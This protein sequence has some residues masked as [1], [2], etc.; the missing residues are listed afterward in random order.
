MLVRTP[1]PFP[2]ESLFGYVL[3]VSE[4]NGYDTPG[5]ILRLAGFEEGAMKD[6]R[7]P[8]EQLAVILGVPPGSLEHIAYQRGGEGS[9]L[10]ILGHELGRTLSGSPLRISKPALC[11]Y[12]VEES[13]HIAAFWDLRSAVACPTHGCRV[14][15]TCP[16]CG[17]ALT[18]FR[19]GLLTCKCGA[20]LSNGGL[21]AT[22]QPLTELMGVIKAMLDGQPL[23]SL[24]N[25]A[26]FPLEHLE[27]ISLR[28]LHWLLDRL[29]HL[30]IESKGLPAVGIGYPAEAAVEPLA[31]WPTGYHQFLTRLGHRSLAENPAAG[32]LSKQFKGLYSALSNKNSPLA[33]TSGFMREEF[34]AFGLNMWG[35]GIVDNKLWREARPA[36]R[37]F[38][39]KS[40]FA[41]QHGIWKPSMERMIADGTI[42]TRVITAGRAARILVDLEHTRIPAESAGTVTVREAAELLGIPVSVLEGLRSSGVFVTKLR[43]GRE[44]SWHVD[45]VEAFLVRGLALATSQETER[46]RDSIALADVMRVK[47]RDGDANTDI[48]A[49]L[50][51]GRLPVVGLQGSNLGGLLVKRSALNEFILR[52]GVIEG[53][54]FSFQETA[55]ITGLHPLGLDDAMRQGLISSV[56]R[57]GRR[58]VLAASVE[59]F[60]AE[61]VVLRVVAEALGVPVQQLANVGRNAGVPLVKLR[62][63]KI[64]FQSVLARRDEPALRAAW[65]AEAARI[66]SYVSPEERMAE[67]RLNHEAALQR[68]LDNLRAA[69]ERLPRISGRLNKCGIAK[70]CGFGRDVLYD[71]PTVDTMLEAYNREERERLGCGRTVLESVGAYLDA[72]RLAG[73]TLPKLTNGRLNRLAIAKACGIPRNFL[74]KQPQL[75]A[76]LESHPL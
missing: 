61:F 7:F 54:S 40:E 31:N 64:S 19:P 29:G 70:A 60:N 34:V 76:L 10:K 38:I 49:A 51:D 45:D 17:K 56:E 59:Q 25:T 62:R 12:C 35:N 50:F 63:A 5:H 47:L 37:R 36:T 74:Y 75:M 27:G 33:A 13:G 6:A 73:E 26:R 44:S 3:R 18:W 69:G 42:V 15:R 4:V 21:P 58:R 23:S 72:L 41:R 30:N 57:D 46:P 53:N 52:K 9:M 14:L 39:S 16:S 2:T 1:A 43:V 11:P 48:V 28:A 20:S 67:R 55:R 8:V 32:G 68:Y 71:F 22:E 24:P 65:H 66:A